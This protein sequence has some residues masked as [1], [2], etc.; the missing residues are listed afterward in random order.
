MRR[1]AFRSRRR[2]PSSARNPTASATRATARASYPWRDNFCE[3]RSFEVWQCAGGYGHQGEDI[4]AAACPPPGEGARALRSQ[5]AR[6]RRRARR[7]R[8][9]RVQGPGRDASSQQSHRAHPLPLHAHEP[10]RD[11]RR[12]RA[13][14]AASSPKA[15]RSAWS[16]T[17]STIPPERRCICISTCRYS[18]AT[19]GSGS[20][21]TSRW[22]RPMSA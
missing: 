20:A 1:S 10:A 14:T 13:S 19:A 21:P 3:S 17:S 4:R 12:W 5:A 22:S 7:H 15:R 6:R 16:R 2:R 18:P 8:D 9:P 11:E